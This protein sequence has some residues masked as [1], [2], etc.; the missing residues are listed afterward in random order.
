MSTVNKMVQYFSEHS[1]NN[2]LVYDDIVEKILTP[3]YDNIPEEDW[4]LI[5]DEVWKMAYKKALSDD[6]L[7]PEENYNLE[8]IRALSNDLRTP[9]FKQ[10]LRYKLNNHVSATD[11]SNHYNPRYKYPKPTP[12]NWGNEDKS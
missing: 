1:K 2:N 7:T 9:G 3:E 4:A 6:V 10:T 11:N 12:Y 8:M 5:I